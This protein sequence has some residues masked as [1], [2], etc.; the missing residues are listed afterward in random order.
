MSFLRL[1]PP[2]LRPCLAAARSLGPAAV[3]RL[4][5]LQ[6]AGG[7]GGSAL[8]VP[9][10]LS[11]L[12]KTHERSSRSQR[13]RVVAS[14]LAAATGEGARGPCER[15]LVIHGSDDPVIALADSRALCAAKGYELIVVPSGGH[16]CPQL[17]AAATSD[18]DEHGHC[19]SLLGALV[20]RA[21]R[22]PPSPAAV[23]VS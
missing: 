7:G 18:V 11:A 23:L 1:L 20:R 5:R 2:R 9:V 3:R 8:P 22:Q 6:G 4:G 15:T 14:L 19:H 21:A 10:A 12:A 17:E 13:L 16:C